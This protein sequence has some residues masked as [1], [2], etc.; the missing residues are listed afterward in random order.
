MDDF[1]FAEVC[2]TIGKKRCWGGDFVKPDENLVAFT[3]KG[4]EELER[5]RFIPITFDENCPETASER[6]MKFWRVNPV[7]RTANED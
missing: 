3:Q 7:R 1:S 6:A 5:A 2:Y 4:L